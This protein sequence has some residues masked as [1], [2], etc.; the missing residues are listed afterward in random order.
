[1]IEILFVVVFLLVF[2]ASLAYRLG[3]SRTEN[4]L[5]ET[6]AKQSD[7]LLKMADDVSAVG[8]QHSKERMRDSLHSRE[9]LQTIQELLQE[10]ID[11][12]AR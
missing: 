5:R 9:D 11:K 12:S 2:S 7:L 8:I 6:L 4:S 3:V 10:K 1:M